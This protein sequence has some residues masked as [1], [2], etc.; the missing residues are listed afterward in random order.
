MAS[1]T[2]TD[3]FLK[4]ITASS[5]LGQLEQKAKRIQSLTDKVRSA[6]PGAER[7]HVL[8]AAFHDDTLVI[9]TDSAAWSTR[10]R[11]AQDEL[12]ASLNAQGEKTFVH[13]KV[14]VGKE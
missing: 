13:L 6:I 10:I 3:S 11:F 5:L 4:S 7:E 2:M 14:R 1:P 12:R 8:A 9:T